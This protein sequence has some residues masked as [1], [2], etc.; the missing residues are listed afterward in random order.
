M[1]KSQVLDMKSVEKSS[2][3]Y[4]SQVFD[5]KNQVLEKNQVFD[6]KN[7]EKSSFRYKVKFR[8]EKSSFRH[9]KC[10]KVKF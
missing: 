9:E 2:F 4:K 10:R 1:T 5:T 7:V 3:R 6:T 8:H